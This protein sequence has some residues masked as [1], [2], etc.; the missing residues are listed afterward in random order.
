MSTD[1]SGRQADL[2][3]GCDGIRS[4]VRQALRTAG[5]DVEQQR[6]A[7]PWWLV[8]WHHNSHVRCIFLMMS[9]L[10]GNGG[11]LDVWLKYG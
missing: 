1:A 10:S 11:N 8:G 3:L 5:A 7:A 2:V 6:F 4:V 9:N